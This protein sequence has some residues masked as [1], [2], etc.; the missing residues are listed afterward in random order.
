VAFPLRNTRRCRSFTSSVVIN[1]PE[2]QHQPRERGRLTTRGRRTDDGS[3]CTL[4]VVHELDG[5]WSFHGLGA[6]GVRLSAADMV[7]LATAILERC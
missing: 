1:V 3:I 4:L 5:A 2:I 7:E 6:P